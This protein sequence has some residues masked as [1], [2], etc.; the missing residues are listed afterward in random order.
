MGVIRYFWLQNVTNG[1]GARAPVC[2]R[3]FAFCL[4][5]CHF[6]TYIMFRDQS[7]G[8]FLLFGLYL[9]EKPYDFFQ[10]YTIFSPKRL[11]FY[12]CIF[13]FE[14]VFFNTFFFHYKKKAKNFFSPSRAY[15]SGFEFTIWFKLFFLCSLSHDEH[16]DI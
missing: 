16:F 3:L 8:N 4:Q 14:K 12:W 7:E 10:T 11:R 15:I 6:Y 1:S 13:C 2:P 5:R 9:E